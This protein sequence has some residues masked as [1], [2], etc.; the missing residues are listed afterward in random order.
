MVAISNE[1][2][3]NRLLAALPVDQYE[4]LRPSLQPVELLW[5]KWSTNLPDNWIMYSS[6]PPQ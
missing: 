5:A 6:R 4:R 3:E 2:V 1:P